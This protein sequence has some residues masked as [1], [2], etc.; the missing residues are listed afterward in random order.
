[1]ACWAPQPNRR[2]GGTS[3]K[4]TSSQRRNRMSVTPEEKFQT[5]ILHDLEPTVEKELNRHLSMAK[6][7]FPHQYVPWSE[8]RTFDG[9]LDGEPWSI[10]QSKLSVEARESSSSTC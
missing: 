1:M 10:E 4:T 3:G 2:R 9:P 5:G 8:G 6:E 7:W